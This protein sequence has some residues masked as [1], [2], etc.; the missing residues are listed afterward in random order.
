MHQ[1]Y[2]STLLTIICRALRSFVF[3]WVSART[4]FVHLVVFHS[5]H[6]AT[7]PCIWQFSIS[8]TVSIIVDIFLQH[9]IQ[10]CTCSLGHVDV[11]QWNCKWFFS[12]HVQFDSG[13]HVMAVKKFDW[14]W[15]EIISSFT[16]IPWWILKKIRLILLENRLVGLLRLGDPGL[17]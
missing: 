3:S 5:E 6:G 1:T 14:N 10:W 4:M 9:Y 13:F 17:R 11:F 7:C 8:I 12:R 2:V 15:P 16:I